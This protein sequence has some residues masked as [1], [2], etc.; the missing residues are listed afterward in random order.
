MRSVWTFLAVTLGVAWLAALPAWLDGGNLNAH[1]AFAGPAMMFTPTLGVLAVWLLERRPAGLARETG[2][3]LGE[4]KSRT[5]KLFFAGWFA[6]PVLSAAALAASAA[7]GLVTVDLG[8]FG[9]M[10]QNLPAGLP[11][12]A[13]TLV[14]GQVIASVLVAPLVNA[15][16]AFGEE[17]GWRGWLLPRLL[18]L[19]LWPALLLSGVIWGGWHAPL[20]LLGYNYPRLGPWAA[21]M[22]I[23]FCVVSGVL[24][25]WL[26]LRSGSVWPA[27]VA[28]GSINATAGYPVLFGSA[29]DP[30]D[31]AVAG[32]IGVVGWVV[33]ALLGAVVVRLRPPAS[34]RSDN[35]LVEATER[36]R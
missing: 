18:P 26:R 12:D 22:F 31:L 20:T 23:G 6:P 11:I 25:G 32:L 9:L 24:L 35:L 19:G 4:R 10:R 1:L 15:L 28:H 16:L 14:L 27:V 3:R 2:L 21:L 7:L 36:S 33:L 17:W 30:P 34:G 29:Q 5:V 8:G 13:G